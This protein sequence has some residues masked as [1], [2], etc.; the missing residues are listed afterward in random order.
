MIWDPKLLRSKIFRLALVYLCLFSASVL[1]LLGFIYWFATDSVSRQVDATIDAEIRG[2]AEQYEQRGL[3]GLIEILQRRSVSASS[4]RGLYLLTDKAYDRLAGNLSRWPDQTPD[5]NGWITF[6]LGSPDA[7]GSGI[8]FGRARVFDL[9]GGLHLLVGH[10]IRERTRIVSVIRDTLA[11][12]IAITIGLS[13]IGGVLMSRSLL[14]QIE[15]I[16]ETSRDIMAGDL[17]Q[18]IPVSGRGDEFDRLSA[19]LNAMLDQIERLLEG[20]KQVTDNIA[21]DLRSPLARLRSRLEIVLI[22]RSDEAAYREAI[23]QTIGEAD[24]LLETFNALLS[25][26]QAESGVAR[27]RFQPVALDALLRDAAELYEPLAEERGL[28]LEATRNGP[29]TIQGDRNLLFQAV[30]N[31]LDNAIKFSPAGGRIGFALAA[32]GDC[33]VFSIDDQGPGVPEASRE[34][35]LERFYRLESSRSTPGSGLG[36]SL[37]AAVAALHRGS[38]VLEDN[39]P[40]LRARLRLPL[41]QGRIG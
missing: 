14:R 24:K 8:N 18:R 41:D 37:V 27:Q 32:E 33:A 12:G 2:L 9:R 4:T 19:N 5:S 26:A 29:I 20:I 39:A 25:I 34:Q 7:E 17:S 31:L 3:P 1:I 16:N 22:G 30:A 38:L 40:G 11:W 35:V 21:H 28:D 10:D 6:R 23:E 13:L 36:L 15:G